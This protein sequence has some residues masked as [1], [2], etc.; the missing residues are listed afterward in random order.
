[1]GCHPIQSALSHSTIFPPQR[2]M[3]LGGGEALPP[4]TI[5]PANQR[6][7]KWFLDPIIP[8]P[9]LQHESHLHPCPRDQRVELRERQ[10]K[11]VHASV[12]TRQLR[13]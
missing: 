12:L 8:K 10:L 11:R 5:S 7:P 13:R 9:R 3:D 4:R 1:M 6:T 2:H